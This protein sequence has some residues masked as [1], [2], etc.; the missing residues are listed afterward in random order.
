[1]DKPTDFLMQD[2]CPW[3]DLRRLTGFPNIRWCEDQV[4]SWIAT[5]ANTW[6]NLGYIAVGFFFVWM[7]RRERAENIR[8]YGT[9]TLWVGFTS[10]L[11][12]ASLTFV[13]QVFDFFG[14]FILFYLLLVQNLARLGKVKPEKVK[15]TVWICTAVTTLVSAICDKLGFPLQG[16]VM[17]LI[18]LILVTEVL[19]TKFSELK[20]RHG[21]FFASIGFLA[22]GASFS[23]SDVTRRFCDP[24]DHW[25]QGHAIWHYFGALAVFFS[26]FHYRQFYSPETGDMVVRGVPVPMN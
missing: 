14:M 11:Y 1:M 26:I 9:A 17:F 3:V 25:I 18:L 7:V 4:C 16:L 13:T 2:G 6:S 12:H 8:F 15:R 20:I 19:A 22:I 5:P 10:F 24:S 21:S 23:A